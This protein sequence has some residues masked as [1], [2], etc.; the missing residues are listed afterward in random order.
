[1]GFVDIPRVRTQHQN[2]SIEDYCRYLANTVALM[3]ESLEYVVNG[4]INSKNVLE[5]G[6]WRVTKDKLMSA[7]EGIYPR[8][9]L[10]GKNKFVTV[11]YTATDYI[12]IVPVADETATFEFHS[13]GSAG[14]QYFADDF[15]NILTSKKVNINGAQGT[16][17][18]NVIIDNG[19]ML[20]TITVPSAGTATVE[21]VQLSLNELIAALQ[22]MRILA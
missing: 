2:E 4:K 13:N 15:F 11:Y 21:T 18:E 3:S 9:E 20:G 7:P 22:S 8:I 5:V 12:T 1:M 17:F 16:Y 6:S 14:Y 10:S 19:T